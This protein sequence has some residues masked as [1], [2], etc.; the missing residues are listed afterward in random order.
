MK[1]VAFEAN[2]CPT[3]GLSRRVL[4]DFD[5]VILNNPMIHSVVN[6]RSAEWM[7]KHLRL[8]DAKVAEELNCDTYRK[9]G[10]SVLYAGEAFGSNR[11]LIDAYND[12]VFDEEFLSDVVPKL[13]TGYDM[14][15]TRRI[16]EAGRERSLEFVLC[17]NPPLRYVERVLSVQG[18]SLDEMFT[19]HRFTSDQLGTV[20]PLF[21]FYH[22][23]E[24][25][26]EDSK[27]LHFID[28]SSKNVRCATTMGWNAIAMSDEYEIV[29]HL[30]TYTIDESD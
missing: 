16:F 20:K 5:G 4:L 3:K 26:L 11:T 28:D 15:R 25:D 22:A 1:I 29:E 18:F 27:Q 7:S 30:R 23:V 13:S 2:S 21:D 17:A 14:R 10:H 8:A 6:R 9:Q 19:G 12:F 24:C